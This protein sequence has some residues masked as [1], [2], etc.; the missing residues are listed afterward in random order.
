M[1]EF[2]DDIKDKLN[3]SF[4]L[5]VLLILI[6]ERFLKTYSPEQAEIATLGYFAIVIL[7]IWLYL[8]FYWRKNKLKQ[9]QKKLKEELII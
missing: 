1:K 9:M 7:Y 4:T 5:I 3:F 2:V 6:I 8:S